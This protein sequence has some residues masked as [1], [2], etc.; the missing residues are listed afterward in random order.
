M[1]SSAKASPARTNDYYLLSV[2]FLVVLASICM[3]LRS[4][5]SATEPTSTSVPR[6]ARSECD[7]PSSQHLVL[8]DSNGFQRIFS[9]FRTPAAIKD[10]R[11]SEFWGE[12][13]WVRRRV[14]ATSKGR[15]Q[16]VA[17]VR[18]RYTSE[19]VLIISSVAGI[20]GSVIWSKTEKWEFIRFTELDSFRFLCVSS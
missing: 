7:P 12:I 1:I 9:Y 20:L 2:L 3:T 13:C 17:N 11:G 14:L 16:C 6:E 8:P 18:T 10:Q 4:I 19:T 5:S 15:L